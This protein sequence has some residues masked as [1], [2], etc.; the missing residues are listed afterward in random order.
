MCLT[1][2]DSKQKVSWSQWKG[3]VAIRQGIKSSSDLHEV[4][5]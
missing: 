2:L 5:W 1:R 4:T 3:Q